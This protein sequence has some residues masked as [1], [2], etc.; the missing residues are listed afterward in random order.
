MGENNFCMS[1]E[2]GYNIFCWHVQIQIKNYFIPYT[3]TTMFSLS[4]VH[5]VCFSTLMEI[6][7]SH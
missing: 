1:L 2:K 7:A 5:T 3:L 4:Y 6:F